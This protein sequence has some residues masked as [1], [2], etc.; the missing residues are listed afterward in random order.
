MN[1]Q[2]SVQKKTSGRPP[3]GVWNFFNRGSS[4]K[5]HCSGT[6]KECGSFWECA[7]PVDL[8]EHL[9]LD[10]PTQN[11][12]V[13]NF[14]TQIIANRQGHGQT[15]SQEN[16]PGAEPSKKKCKITSD[17]ATLSEFLKSTKLTP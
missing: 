7:K 3:A 15:A 1:S 12:D 4:V 2:E 11:K 17:Q 5:G 8:E 14:Y 6:R 9:A 10:C 13:I 16:I